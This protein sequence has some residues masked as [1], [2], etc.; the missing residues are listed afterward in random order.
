[1]AVKKGDKVKIEYT[2]S[3]DDGTVFDSSEHDGHHH[4]LEFEAGAGQ[5][6]PGFDEAVNGMELNE[7][8]EFRL[9]S[10]DAY[11]EPKK[12]LVRPFPKKQLPES[13]K[14]GMM[15]GLGMPNG[16]QLPGMIKSVGKEEVIIDFNHPLAGKSLNFKVKLV[17]IN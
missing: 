12:E 17:A 14:E 4:P 8:K 15:I 6:V 3:F 9:E 2:G 7:E 13:V 5:V 10:K 11:G 16:Q 1:M